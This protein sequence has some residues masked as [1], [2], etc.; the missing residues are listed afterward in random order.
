MK[1]T[2]MGNKEIRKYIDSLKQSLKISYDDY[3]RAMIT[4]MVKGFEES[5][6][7]RKEEIKTSIAKLDCDFDVVLDPNQATIIRNK[8]IAMCTVIYTDCPQPNCIG[9]VTW[10]QLKKQVSDEQA[11]QDKIEKFEE[12]KSNPKNLREVLANKVDDLYD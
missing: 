12:T 4:G 5:M 7:M 6:S 2:K 11:A 10:E 1:L 9:D 8:I 3:H